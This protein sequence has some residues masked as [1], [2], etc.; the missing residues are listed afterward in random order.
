M[1]QRIKGTHDILPEE[2]AVWVRLEETA[3]QVFAPFGFQEIRPPVMEWTELFARGIGQSTDIVEKEM[4]T[5]ADSQG[6]SISL[7]PEATAGVVRAFLENKLY[8]RHEECKLFTMGPMFRHERPQKGRYR[9][10]HQINVEVFGNPGPRVDAE[11]ILMLHAYLFRTG[12]RQA[13]LALNS[14]GCPDCRPAFRRELT[15]FLEA[16]QAGLCSDCVRRITLN[17]LRVL[18]CKVPSCREVVRGAPSIHDH[19]CSECREHFAEVTRLLKGFDI[20]FRIDHH[21]VRGL[22][23]YTRTAFEVIT[24]NLGAQDAVAGGGRYDRLT[25]LLGGPP[26]PAVGFAIGM[27][28]L[29]LVC[30][31]K[32]PPFR[33][34]LYIAPLGDKALDF[35]FSLANRLRLRGATV[36]LSHTPRSLKSQMR[37]ADKLQ[38]AKVLII[39]D[40]ELEKNRGSLRDMAK[41]TQTEIPLDIAEEEFMKRVMDADTQPPAL[42]VPD[43]RL[44]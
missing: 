17:P 44:P 33:P 2:A 14:L 42:A 28:R 1:I 24:T 43:S 4:Y 30:D 41:G 20:P 11:L 38:A 10:F 8:A 16:R 22:D 36:E 7:R 21:L 12:V 3:R 23:Y 39:G 13:E 29:A 5:F 6:R 32:A 15:G 9:Q 40:A 25:E 35:A 34:D 37:R 26:T 27:E 19:L 31:V 18:D